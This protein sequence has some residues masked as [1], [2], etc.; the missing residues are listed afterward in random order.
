M[1]RRFIGK[2][3]FVALTAVAALA[4]AGAAIAFFTQAG[5]GTGTA[6]VG[7]SSAPT[8][9]GTITGALYPAGSAAGVSVLVTNTGQ[10][11]Q[12]VDKVHLDSIVIDHSSS[13][14]TGA[15]SAQQTTWNACDTSTS[16]VNPAFTMA[17]ISVATDLTKSG[18]AGDNTTKIGS[19]QMNDTGVSQNNCQSAPLQLNFSSN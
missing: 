10:G 6:S 13:T 8:V 12:Y 3:K 19:L 16:G 11:S 7:T 4:I 2:R 14:Y 18:T 15:S 9:A 1:F 5:G 17:D